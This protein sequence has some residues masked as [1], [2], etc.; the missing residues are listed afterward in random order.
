MRTIKFMLCLN[1]SERIPQDVTDCLGI[2]PTKTT[3]KGSTV[4]GTSKL[5]H[6]YNGWRLDIEA[7]TQLSIAPYFDSLVERINGKEKLFHKLKNEGWFIEVACQYF[8]EP[9]RT[10]PDFHLESKHI[11]FLSE[12]CAELD[13]DIL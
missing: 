5:V 4:G 9:E 11:L 1:H 7:E 10:T 6:K 2:A 13:L 12:I 3:M 8:L